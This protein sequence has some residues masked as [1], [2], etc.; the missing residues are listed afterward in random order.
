MAD[1]RRLFRLEALLSFVGTFFF[2]KVYHRQFDCP[3][4]HFLT[5]MGI[6]EENDRL[7]TENEYSY[8]VA[9]LVYCFRVLALQSLLPVE[10][11]HMQG[12]AEFEA[13]LAQR[14][15]YLADGSMSAMST[16]ISLLAYGK[17]L[18]M[19]PRQLQ[20]GLLGEEQ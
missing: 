15:E 6:D 2:D 5:V 13:F 7:R 18:A 12:L 19:K 17:Y 4:V 16:M 20:G 14:R 11:R 1:A 8:R 10:Q 3:T 9:G